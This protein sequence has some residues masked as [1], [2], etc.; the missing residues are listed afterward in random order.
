MRVGDLV[1]LSSYVKWDNYGLITNVISESLVEVAWL[2]SEYIY[3]E[4]VSNLEV[5]NESW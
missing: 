3:M 1:R 4:P 5:V 2:G